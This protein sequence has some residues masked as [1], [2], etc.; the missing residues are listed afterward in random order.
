MPATSK[1]RRVG[2]GTPAVDESLFGE[3]EK[4]IRRTSRQAAEEKKGKVVD[5]SAASVVIS[6]NQLR[7]IQSSSIIKTE[8]MIHAEKM[9]RERVKAEKEH[10]AR[11]RRDKMIALNSHAKKNV[12]KSD[13][14]VAAASK[15][16]QLRL[17]GE[18]QRDRDSDV[19]KLLQSFASRA[20]AFSVR[21]AQLGDREERLAQNREY[22]RRMDTVM[23]VDRLNDLRQ[24]ESKEQTKA[25]ARLDDSSVLM[26]QIAARQRARMLAEDAKEQ[27]AISIKAQMQRYKDQEAEEARVR[28][29]ELDKSRKEVMIAN[30]ASIANRLLAREGEKKEIADILLYQAEQDAK[31]AAREEEEAALVKLKSDQQKKLL[32]LQ[33]KSQNKAAEADELR[34]RRAMEHKER[35]ARKEERDKALK[36]RSETNKLLTEREKQTVAKTKQRE[37]EKARDMY[38]WQQSIEYTNK[39]A[40]RD[41][42]ERAAKHTANYRHRDMLSEQI[43]SDEARKVAARGDE[44]D[45]GHKFRQALI[46][47]EAKFSTIRDQMVADLIRKGVNPKYVSDMQKLDVGKILRR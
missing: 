14:E 27:E 15:A 22:D 26:Q 45:A 7:Q 4:T 43:K 16:A 25:K 30:E 28:A 37:Y 42:D 29:I 5:L 33:E 46:S 11:A 35:I 24:R 8:H 36:I 38:E 40:S 6:E 3:S 21:D 20:T 2:G 39:N 32:A 12:R 47:D 41:A 31:M 18:S 23:E 9:E 17:M 44:L 13:I 34:A 10:V 19:V 1:Y